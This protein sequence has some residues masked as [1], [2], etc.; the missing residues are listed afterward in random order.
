MYLLY[1]D[2]SGKH[3][4][5]NFVLCGIAIFERQVYFA[6]KEFDDFQQTYFPGIDEPVELHATEIRYGASPWDKLERE[7]RYSLLDN[8]YESIR[9][10]DVTIISSII[11]RQSYEDFI[12]K[13][14]ESDD[15]PHRIHDLAEFDNGELF[16]LEE[17]VYLRAFEEL[18]N[19][20]DLFLDRVSRKRAEEHRGMILMAQSEMRQRIES[21][22][23]RIR[24]HGTQWREAKRLGE[25]MPWFSPTE[26][27]RLLQMADLCAN[28]IYGYFEKGYAA[29]FERI[30]PK[31][32]KESGVVHGIH[33]FAPDQRN[34]P[35][36]GCVS[37][38][39]TE[40]E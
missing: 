40:R 36:P 22:A 24:R 35:C 1:I 31:F 38:Q 11:H 10:Q 20:F 34:C 16:N 25:L 15:D 14:L 2:E 23:K 28:A 29:Q 39:E 17:L 4:A 19:R 3:A 30:F 12:W 9:N 8:L 26:N 21:I 5:E 32:D 37:R 27:S 13:K 7:E 18:V 33:H 6:A